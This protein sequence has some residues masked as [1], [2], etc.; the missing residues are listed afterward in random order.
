M[1]RLGVPGSVPLTHALQRIPMTDAYD[2]RGPYVASS[3]RPPRGG[4]SSAVNVVIAG[5][6]AAVLALALSFVTGGRGDGEAEAAAP[7]T[8]TTPTT[9][10]TDPA[11]VAETTTTT[12]A[13]DGKVTL[14][15]AGDSTAGGLGAALQPLT[16]EQ[17]I[18]TT[19]DYKVSSGL[20]RPDFYSWPDRLRE[21]VPIVNPEIVVVMFGGNDA[22]PI[23]IPDGRNV[24]VTA[25]EWA[26]EYA[27]RVGETMDY[28][29][30]DGRK[31]I[32]VGVPTAN[33]ADF[34]QRLTVL[35]DVLLAEAGERP[36]V[37]F[38]DT[39]NLFNGPDG[40]YADYVVDEGDGL[41]KRM[42]AKD[43]YHLNPAGAKRLARI[44]DA[45]I[46]KEVGARTGTTPPPPT[47]VAPPEG[48]LG[49]YNVE[50]GDAWAL[51]ARRLG[52]S[53]DRLLAVNGAQAD[54]PLFVDQK[55][56]VPLPA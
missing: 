10:A 52:V 53:L 40:T 43:G 17:G 22:Q 33:G 25:P 39:W 31:L 24:N 12:A 14:Y 54:M 35:R 45:E 18:A 34:N 28:L 23:K 2:A 46:A 20:T 48:A 7:A 5:L 15:I 26:E 42:R 3:P 1:T 27:K 41:A 47:T 50:S 29:S 9:I 55:V 30:A 13:D 19:V 44:V 16:D 51:I 36:Q 56:K 4:G 49:L 38:V 37:T 21:Q 6:V 32:W 11:A 8:E